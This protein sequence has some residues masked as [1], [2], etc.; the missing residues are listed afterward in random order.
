MTLETE[1]RHP[2]AHDIVTLYTKRTTDGRKLFE[3]TSPPHRRESGPISTF[4]FRKIFQTSV[5]HHFLSF[6]LF[7]PSALW[8][9]FDL[10]LTD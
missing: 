8:L 2:M 9:I 5:F 6:F 10:S 7:L 1:Q 3:A 4:Y